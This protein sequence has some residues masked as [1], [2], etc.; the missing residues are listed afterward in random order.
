ME[1]FK[2]MLV[3]WKNIESWV[4]EIKK[5]MDSIDYMP[6]VII[7]LSRGGLVPARILSDYLQLKD[8]YAIKTEHWGITATPDGQAKITQGLPINIKGKNVLIIDDITDTGQSLKVAY[9]YIKSFDPLILKSA[10]LLHIT[11]SQ[12]IPDFYAE[13]VL[14]KNWTWFI[15]PWNVYEDITTII[16]KMLSQEDLT[17]EKIQDYFERYFYIKPKKSTINLSIKMLMDKKMIRVE[18]GIYKKL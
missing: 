11:R 17:F 16:M 2:C 10:T 6:D 18:K 7:G 9:E 15:F 13:E 12:F 8:L 3:S 1:G 5:K 14:E 4:Y